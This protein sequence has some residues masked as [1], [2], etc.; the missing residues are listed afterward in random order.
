MRR[1]RVRDATGRRK[2]RSGA[3][4][5]GRFH[6][7]LISAPPVEARTPSCSERPISGGHKVSA[8]QFRPKNC[9]PTSMHVPSV[10]GPTIYQQAT[11]QD[12]TAMLRGVGN[13]GRFATRCATRMQ[14]TSSVAKGDTTRT[15]EVLFV[16]ERL[17]GSAT[18]PG[19]SAL[20]VRRTW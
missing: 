20:A 7:T 10:C 2:G 3:F 19:L 13:R 8:E 6:P 11:W 12:M 18:C 16:R 5:N 14:A 15:A 1:G 4:W 17:A 9:G